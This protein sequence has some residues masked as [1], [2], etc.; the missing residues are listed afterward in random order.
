MTRTLIVAFLLGGVFTSPSSALS[1]PENQMTGALASII[2]QVVFYRL[3]G[4]PMPSLKNFE[5]KSRWC[6]LEDITQLAD[7]KSTTETVKQI[8]QSCNLIRVRR[9]ANQGK[10]QRIFEIEAGPQHCS[11]LAHAIGESFRELI[12]IKLEKDSP[13]KEL[14]IR[15]NLFEIKTTIFGALTASSN[16]IDVKC[17]ESGRL[18]ILAKKGER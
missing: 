6:N 9:P 15:H 14:H 5:Q 10:Y 4:Y 16:N 12:G 8:L 17:T 2:T 18:I 1:T 13:N 3:A 7:R 11:H